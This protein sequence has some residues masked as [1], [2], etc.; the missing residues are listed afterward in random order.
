VSYKQYTVR[1]ATQQMAHQWVNRQLEVDRSFAEVRELKVHLQRLLRPGSKIV[2]AGC[3]IGGWV[4][5]I[6][7]MGHNVVGIDWYDHIVK[8]ARETDPTLNVEQGDILNLRYPDATFDAYISLGVIEHFEEG[9]Q[10]ALK[11]A[12]RVL[13]PGGL[14]VVTVPALTVTRRLLAHPFRSL[15]VAALK[16]MG[17]EVFFAEYRY[18]MKELVGFMKEAGFEIL[19]TA[20]DDALPSWKR[21]HI[22]L[23]CDWP[24]LRGGESMELSGLGRIVR[25]LYSLLPYGWYAGGILVVGRRPVA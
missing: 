20:T 19:E 18:S 8:A 1:D 17:R 11:E 10:K 16:F 22:G 21:H 15:T 12:L 2:E 14:A 23:Y 13:K 25:H 9:P 3:G 7:S 24:F 5:I 4:K 6:Q